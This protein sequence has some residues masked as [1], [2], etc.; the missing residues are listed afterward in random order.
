[1]RCN[2]R[3]SLVVL[4]VNY[5]ESLPQKHVSNIYAARMNFDPSK[6]SI[7]TLLQAP[8]Y[9]VEQDLVYLLFR[10]Y[11]WISSLIILSPLIVTLLH[12]RPYNCKLF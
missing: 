9:G 6:N 1:M 11:I 2:G 8:K 7:L 3:L 5:S 12:L 10:Q 4:V